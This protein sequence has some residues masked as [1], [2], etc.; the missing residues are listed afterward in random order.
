LNGA[1]YLG[2]SIACPLITAIIIQGMIAFVMATSGGTGEDGSEAGTGTDIMIT[3]GAAAMT[4]GAEVMTA[5]TV[6]MTA[7]EDKS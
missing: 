4:A 2:S 3:G 5:G 7:G 6:I 1:G